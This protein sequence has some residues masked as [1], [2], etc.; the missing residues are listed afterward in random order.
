LRNTLVEDGSW[1]FIV[2]SAQ[3]LIKPLIKLSSLIHLGKIQD[4]M[5]KGPDAVAPK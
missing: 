1:L 3:L 2:G 5:Q 4:Q